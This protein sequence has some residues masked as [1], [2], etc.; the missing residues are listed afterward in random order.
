MPE[1]TLAP[2]IP[3]EWRGW[4]IRR[5][6][7]STKRDLALKRERLDPFT[8]RAVEA[9]FALRNSVVH[10]A[11]GFSFTFAKYLNTPTGADFIQRLAPT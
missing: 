7:V 9:L 6:T 5:V 10:D 4:F 8:A 11:R 2:A 3:A 1:L